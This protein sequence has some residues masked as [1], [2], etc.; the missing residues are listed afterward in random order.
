[1]LK[2][3]KYNSRNVKIKLTKLTKD[4]IIILIKGE[5]NVR[6]IRFGIYI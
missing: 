6:K 3:F 2:T 4:D 5:L 1:M